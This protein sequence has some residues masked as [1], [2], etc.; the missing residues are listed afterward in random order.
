VLFGERHDADV[1]AVRVHDRGVEGTTVDVDSR[2]GRLELDIALPGRGQVWNVLA[3]TAV[4]LEFGVP[5]S[6][7]VARARTLTPVDR[8]GAVTLLPNGVRLVDDSYNASPAAVQMM[9]EALAATPTAG[10]RIAVLGE[11]LELGEWS[12][13]LHETCGRAAAGTP[14]NA[15]VAIGGDAA[16]GLVAG[17]L[18]GGLPSQAIHRFADSASAAPH[19][20]ALVQPG[21]LVLVKGSRG[22]RTDLVADRLR[23]VA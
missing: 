9:L 11:M 10:R 12:W 1:R 13:A 17:A 23:E 3:A 22:T 16:D 5:P 21:D 6:S 18:A 14:V 8:R 4:A 19:V 15:L 20:A 2:V 7:I